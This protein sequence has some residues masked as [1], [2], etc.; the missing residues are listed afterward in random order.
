MTDS[1][2]FFMGCFPFA[3]NTGKGVRW[4]IIRHTHHSARDLMDGPD[5][6]EYQLLIKNTYQKGPLRNFFLSD[7]FLNAALVKSPDMDLLRL[8]FLDALGN[9]ES[10]QFS[11][12]KDGYN[13]RQ[14]PDQVLLA[15]S[16]KRGRH[17]AAGRDYVLVYI[18]N[19]ISKG[20]GQ[21]ESIKKFLHLVPGS[22]TD[23]SKIDWFEKRLRAE[24]K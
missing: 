24:R 7:V 1:N 15:S 4:R 22:A 14:N 8:I 2:D 19:E 23:E 13:L 17:R 12:F 21:T 3:P 10:S 5:W 11:H 18:R 9:D 6:R 16:P 20:R